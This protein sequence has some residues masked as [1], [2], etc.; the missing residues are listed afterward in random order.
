[1]LIPKDRADAS[2]TT[3]WEKTFNLIERGV[4]QA[5]DIHTAINI[6]NGFASGANAHLRLGR[7]EQAVSWFHASVAKH[8]GT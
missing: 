1:M 4:F 6:Q 5:E 3:H 2:W 8:L 7:I